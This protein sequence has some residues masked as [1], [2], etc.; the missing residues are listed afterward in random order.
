MSG[1][2]PVLTERILTVLIVLPLFLAALFWL[3]QPYWGVAGLAV[4]LLACTE[5]SK[6]A[7]L[8]AWRG[9]V[10]AAAVG[11]GCVVMGVLQESV[12]ADVLLGVAVVFWIAVVP[13]WLRQTLAATPARL[14]VAGWIVLVSAWYSLFVLQASSARL[15]V[16]LGVVWVADTAAYFAGRR[17][18]RHKLAPAI[19]PGKTWEGVG[20]AA[21]AVGLYYAV[22]WIIIAPPFLAGDRLADLALVAGMTLL[23]VEGDLFE[24]WVKRKAGV[25]DSGTLLPGHGGVLDRID[26]L[27]AA[28][29][30]AALASALGRG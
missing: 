11:L 14:A 3:S 2:E 6:L 23:S 24:S 7:V 19:S 30:L 1:A 20:G 13:L 16:L 10:F 4:V 5:W 17:F 25:K 26:G 8:P 28:L 9:G 15:L 12:V 18:G 27:V 29:P 21:L 22:L